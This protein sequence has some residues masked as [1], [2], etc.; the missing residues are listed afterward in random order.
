MHQNKPKNLEANE[1]PFIGLIK[2]IGPFYSPREQTK[3]SL[4]WQI[5]IINEKLS[6]ILDNMVSESSHERCNQ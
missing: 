5:I 4:L 2:S 1:G 6:N 3:I